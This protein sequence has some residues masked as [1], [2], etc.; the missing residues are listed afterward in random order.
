MTAYVAPL[1]DMRFVMR[2]IANMKAVRALPGYNDITDDLVDAILEEAG[3]LG[4]EVLAP[5]NASGDRQGC[6]LANGMVRVPEGFVEAYRQFVAGGWNSIALPSEYGGQG[7]PCLVATAVGEIWN[8]ANLAFAVCPILTQAA[9][10]LLLHH[11]DQ[12]MRADYLPKLASGEWT[13]TMLL[14]EE[15]A[16]SDLARVRTRAL[17]K[18]DHFRIFGQK[19]FITYGEHDLAPNIIHAVLARTPNAPEGSEGLSLFLV[20]KFLVDAD[21]RLGPRNDLHCLSI[22]NKMGIKAS[23]TAV[24]SLGDDCGA[25]GFLIGE[26]NRGLNLM[27]TMMNNVRLAV[28][29]EGVGIADRA[30]QQARSY[31]FERVQGRQLGSDHPEAVAIIRH[32][33]VQRM[34]L[35]M[36]SQTEA[37]RALAYFTA[38]V[39]D[40]ARRHPD[41]DTRRWHQQLVDLLTPVVKAWCT[42]IGIHVVNTGIQ[43]Q[44]GTGYMEESGAPQFLRDSR[45]TAIYEGTNG[46]QAMDL[47]GRKVARDGGVAVRAL[48]DVILSADRDLAA[49]GN[50]DIQVIRG[51]LALA[52]ADLTNATDWLIDTYPLNPSRAAAGAV[53][54]LRLLGNVVSGWLMAKAAAKAAEQLKRGSDHTFLLAKLKSARYFA[55]IRLSESGALRR[56]FLAAGEGLRGLDPDIHL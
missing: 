34:L 22:E 44:G 46:I 13:G 31:A 55:D 7:L 47:V 41:D 32:P 54:Y 5:L 30:F 11:G 8:A 51:S 4:A 48:T 25:I 43:V 33:D 18:G 52:V 45:I 29:V 38:A 36:K 40:T 50:A 28:G 53:F 14:T 35:T 56:K 19:I 24:M 20:P 10:E 15:Q 9:A 12:R 39:L 21:G 23:P 42:D 3:R 16:G 2:E 49:V 26:E 27:F 17:P 37:A 1:A 6:I